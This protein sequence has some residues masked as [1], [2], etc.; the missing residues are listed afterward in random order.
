[1]R[2]VAVIDGT[3]PS[4]RPIVN[5]Q[6]LHPEVANSLLHYLQNAPVV[7]AARSYDTDMFA[8]SDRDVPMNFHTDGTFIWPGAVWH[9]LRK[10]GLPPSPELMEHVARQGYRVPDVS[11]AARQAAVQTIVGQ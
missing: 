3:D 8:P 9:Y 2:I 1:M 7:L 10:Y 11:E 4:G 6:Q 5:R